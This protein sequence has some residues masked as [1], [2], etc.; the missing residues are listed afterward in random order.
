MRP[1]RRAWLLVACALALAAVGWTRRT[2]AA[3]AGA[4]AAP[5]ATA[6]GV[7]PDKPARPVA[8]I[9]VDSFDCFKAED[10]AT[11]DLPAVAG[12][13]ISAWNGG[14]PGGAVWNAS[15]LRCAATIRT[16]CEAGKVTIELRIGKA[17][18]ATATVPIRGGKGDWRAS[19]HHRQWEKN[20]DELSSSKGVPY[21]TAIFRVTALL[22]CEGP[23]QVGPGIGPRG[24]FAADSM[25]VAGF[26]H[27][28]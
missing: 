19:L 2:R 28:E 20:F 25:F 15:E 10:D 5:T 7:A 4:R 18:A 17:T 24:E 21:R 8:P 23:Y 22:T 6:P 9:A 14:G 1:A 3:D 13:G 11:E 27:G 16:T 12:R 26:A